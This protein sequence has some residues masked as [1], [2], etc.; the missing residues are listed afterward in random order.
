MKRK[1][2][3]RIEKYFKSKLLKKRGSVPLIVL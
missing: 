3:L 1:I 2:A